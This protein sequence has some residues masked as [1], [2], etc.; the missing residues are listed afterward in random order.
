MVPQLSG[1]TRTAGALASSGANSSAP[2]HEAAAAALV[3]EDEQGAAAEE[4]EE[5]G[6]LPAEAAGLPLRESKSLT[7]PSSR[8]AAANRRS[9][10]TDKNV[11]LQPKADADASAAATAGVAS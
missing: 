10:D 2:A 5:A 7:S 6:L 8:T 9:S 3:E 1:H 11:L 4:A